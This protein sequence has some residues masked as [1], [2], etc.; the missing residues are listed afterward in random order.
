MAVVMSQVVG[1]MV[2]FVAQASEGGM[3]V[4]FMK[5]ASCQEQK[6]IRGGPMPG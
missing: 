2:Y 6:H 3:V 4:Y 5:R 1:S